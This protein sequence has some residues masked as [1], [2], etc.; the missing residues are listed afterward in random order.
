MS[1]TFISYKRE[2]KDC[3]ARLSAALKRRGIDC[4]WDLNLE[5]GAEPYHR[6]IWRELERSDAV[7]VL[8]CRDAMNSNWVL[9]EA[10][11]A[12]NTGKL[13]S[14]QIGDVTMMPPFNLQQLADLRTW[15]GGDSDHSLNKIVEQVNRLSRQTPARPVVAR[16]PPPPAANKS[17]QRLK[18]DP[19]GGPGV[20]RTIQGAV[21]AAGLDAV[22]E[23]APGTYRESLTIRTRMT[24]IG[25]SVG[26][27][28]PRIIGP[29]AG[30][31]A[32]RV[33]GDATLE[34]LAIAQ[35]DAS[36]VLW[37]QGGAPRLR[38]LSVENVG[39]PPEGRNA[40]AIYVG[41]E[42]RPDAE[43]VSI[44]P[45]CSNGV[46]F[47][48]ESGGRWRKLRIR[49]TKLSAIMLTNQAA[50]YIAD[51]QIENCDGAGVLVRDESAGE[52]VGVTIERL[53]GSGFI[54]GNSAKPTLRDCKAI[55]VRGNAV[56]VNDC[57]GGR[58]DR[59]EFYRTGSSGVDKDIPSIWLDAGSS[60]QFLEAKFFDP[61][62]DCVHRDGGAPAAGMR[63]SQLN[64]RPIVF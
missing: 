33:N 32:L 11:Y 53:A 24:L 19:R 5:T 14:A 1:R 6:Q 15:A 52:F 22:I 62:G 42:A 51:S 27:E 49:K 28:R 21:E 9:S 36:G 56:Q 63:A 40:A 31:D 4:W 44:G 57:A 64:G 12:L 10:Q 23:I 47:A 16:A 54:F 37:L 35:P 50:P 8:W 55:D 41:G 17:G 60:V 59:M 46:Y 39:A 30:L 3:A 58:V 29:G 38:S 25:R 7:L 34:N 61:R 13:I 43:R 45:C 26:M 48:D 18:V 20:H 2:R